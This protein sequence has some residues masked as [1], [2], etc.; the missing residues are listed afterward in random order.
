MLDAMGDLGLPIESLRMSILRI[1]RADEFA[2]HFRS[3][4][5]MLD[6]AKMGEIKR[7]ETRE[8][9]I[10]SGQH[11][12]SMKIDWCRSNMVQFA[13][14]DSDVFVFLARSKVKES[15]GLTALYYAFFKPNEYIVLERQA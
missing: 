3:Y 4:S 6:G 12:L 1:R 11:Q 2:D 15:G 10:P 9:S 5:I 13:A 14:S 8:F 7:G